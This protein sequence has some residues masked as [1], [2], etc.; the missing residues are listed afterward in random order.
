MPLF[1]RNATITSPDSLEA[2]FEKSTKERNLPG[3]VPRTTIYSGMLRLGADQDGQHEASELVIAAI[4]ENLET[5]GSLVTLSNVPGEIPADEDAMHWFTAFAEC[6][7]RRF[8]PHKIRTIGCVFL[9]NATTDEGAPADFSLS[10]AQFD[11]AL[12]VTAQQ[13]P[14]SRIHDMTTSSVLQPLA[15]AS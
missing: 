7:E 3:A 8:D 10:R 11:S 14:D 9:T 15:I 12:S 1:I 2:W 5:A 4:R 6:N 13:L